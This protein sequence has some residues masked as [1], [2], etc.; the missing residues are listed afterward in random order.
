MSNPETALAPVDPAQSALALARAGCL[1]PPG[2]SP[3]DLAPP[4]EDDMEG[5]PDRHPIIRANAKFGTYPMP[6]EDAREAPKVREGIALAR[7]DSRI[8]FPP[9]KENKPRYQQ[10]KLAGLEAPEGGPKWV[11]TCA[12]LR[13]GVAQ[14]NPQLTPEM[15]AAAV[16]AKLGGATGGGCHNCPLGNKA[17][18]WHEDEKG[19]F[20]LCKEGINLLWLDSALGEPSVFQVIA[21]NSVKALREFFAKHFKKGKTAISVY[22]FLIRL[23][24]VTEKKNGDDF[25]VIKPQLGPMS[26]DEETAVYRKLR[27]DLVTMLD[28]TVEAGVETFDA[29]HLD[30]DPVAAEPVGDELPP[31]PSVPGGTLLGPD[32]PLP[33]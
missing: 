6:G 23:G 27:A 16:A 26:N 15:K 19:K 24:F 8:L 25:C 3:S 31:V 2:L 18:A 11:C 30:A 28:A 33:F 21:G 14:L 12:N 29:S 20:Q 7:T 1:L 17:T 10:L 22:K 9:T 4:E 13:T 32:D 5:I